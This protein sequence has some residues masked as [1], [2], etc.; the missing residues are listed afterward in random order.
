[1]PSEVLLVVSIFLAPIF[2]GIVSHIC[3]L[4]APSGDQE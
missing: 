4:R 2:V 3:R 1:M